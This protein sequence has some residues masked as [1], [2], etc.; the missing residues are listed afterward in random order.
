MVGIA[1]GLAVAAS[2]GPALGQGG[3]PTVRPPDAIDRAHGLATKP[4]PKL[5][6]AQTPS[7]RW[8]PERRV[9]SPALGREIV[10]PGHYERRLSDTQSRV[11]TLHGVIP[12]E[13]RTIVIP[14]GDR[15]PAEIRSSP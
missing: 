5:P 4:M 14:G 12:E 3:V 8:V 11:P 10:V 9:F 7:E 15:P 1:L 13:Q 6:D 2:A